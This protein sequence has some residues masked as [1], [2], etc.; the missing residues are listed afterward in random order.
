MRPT[1]GIAPDAK[2]TSS[3]VRLIQAGTFTVGASLAMAFV[4]SIWGGSVRGWLI[5]CLVGTLCAAIWAAG[6]LRHHQSR[7]LRSIGWLFATCIATLY[8]F[9]V[10]LVVAF[11]TLLAWT[12]PTWL[13]CVIAAAT[14]AA[15]V[16]A[17][18]PNRF[19][20]VPAVLPLGLFIAAV[21]SGWLREE[22]FV[23]CDD[24]SSLRAPVQLVVANPQLDACRPG[25]SRPS[26]RFPRT[27]WQAPDGSRIIFTTQ[28]AHAEGGLDGSVCA[29]TLDGREPLECVGPPYGKSQGII[30]LPEQGQILVMQWGVETPR[31]RVGAV[32]LTLPRTGKLEI[33]AENWFDELV[34]EGFYE[35]R[36]STLYM[37]SDRTNG[38]HPARLPS[39][40]LLP[41]IES[42]LAPGEVH[43]DRQ[44]GEGVACGYGLGT[45]IR[46]APYSQRYFIAANSM[47]WDKISLTWGCDWDPL[48]G[49]VYAT[50]PNLGLLNRIDY[51]NGLI[52][53]RWFVGFGMRS[54]A[55]D[56]ARGRVYFTNF[57][58]G[59]VYAFD[60]AAERIV[61]RWF[62]GRFSRWVRLTV[63]GDALLA[64]G[65]LGIVRIPLTD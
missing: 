51:E 26:G 10:Y 50:I 41:M 11:G 39:F 52:E 23:R 60:E 63:D 31:H 55:Y 25:E 62:V 59:E 53:K 43:Y 19:W 54:V 15:V 35:P 14:L 61:D 4:S 32:I 46:G 30:D 58:R 56:K 2:S 28:G 17:L 3:R 44:R 21:L 65:N 6:K 47:P 45:A 7:R 38:I 22:R 27:I 16:S 42:G 49:K 24:L 37:F 36:N 1:A 33:L 48:A 13:W 29:A 18:A 8:V 34:G 5:T 9:W 20:S 40:E 64:T 12:V 57:L